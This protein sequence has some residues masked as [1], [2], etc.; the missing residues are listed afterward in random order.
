LVEWPA[1]IGGLCLVLGSCRPL[2]PP[3]RSWAPAIEWDGPTFLVRL[4]PPMRPDHEVTTGK[5]YGP[6][7]HWADLDLLLTAATVRE[8]VDQS[9]SRRGD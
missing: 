2:A 7:H 6:A 9:L 5:L 4:G 1:H 8:A 3:A